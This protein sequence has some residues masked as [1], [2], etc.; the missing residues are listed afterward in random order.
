MGQD[1]RP[2]PRHSDEGVSM[3]ETL[4]PAEPTPGHQT[5][6][7]ESPARAPAGDASDLFLPRRSLDHLPAASPLGS[8]PVGRLDSMATALDTPATPTL[9][10]TFPET[11]SDGWPLP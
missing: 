4:R 9:T 3:L 5:H 2:L 1:F 6:Q 7:T 10:P 11:I 8:M